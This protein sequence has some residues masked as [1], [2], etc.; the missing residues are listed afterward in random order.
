MYAVSAPTG[1]RCPQP[2]HVTT[3]VVTSN[4]KISSNSPAAALP[5]KRFSIRHL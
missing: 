4:E 2:E 1:F 5:S 3:L